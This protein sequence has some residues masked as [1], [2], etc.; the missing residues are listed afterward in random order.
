MKVIDEI[1]G[2]YLKEVEKREKLEQEI[3]ATDMEIDMMVYELYGLRIDYFV[4]ESCLHRER[5]T[6]V[7]ANVSKVFI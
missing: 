2:V 1:I 6:R 5:H 3:G 7:S 4:I